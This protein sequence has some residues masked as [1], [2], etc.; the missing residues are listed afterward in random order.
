M[1]VPPHPLVI[2]GEEGEIFGGEIG[3]RMSII[4]DEIM[5]GAHSEAIDGLVILIDKS[6]MNWLGYDGKYF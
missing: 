4:V 3:Y 5:N 1:I 6:K 2:I